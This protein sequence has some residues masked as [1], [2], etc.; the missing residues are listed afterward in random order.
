VIAIRLG[1]GRMALEGEMMPLRE[2][3]GPHLDAR[4]HFH[5]GGVPVDEL[6]HA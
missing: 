1:D 5:E 2:D 3:T 4:S 6:V